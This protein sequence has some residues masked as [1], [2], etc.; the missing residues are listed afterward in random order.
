MYVE[1]RLGSD[2][3]TLQP[4]NMFVSEVTKFVALKR[5]PHLTFSVT[6]DYTGKSFTKDGIYKHF[7]IEYSCAGNSVSVN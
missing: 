6:L 3:A 5:L 1:S 2:P 7:K 4:Q